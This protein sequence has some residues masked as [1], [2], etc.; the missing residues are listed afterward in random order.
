MNNTSSICTRSLL[1]PRRRFAEFSEALLSSRLCGL[2]TSLA[3]VSTRSAPRSCL[4]SIAF[5]R[6]S[7]TR[8]RA[9]LRPSSCV[10]C[11]ALAGRLLTCAAIACRL[12]HES[13]RETR[14]GRVRR[15]VR[16]LVRLASGRLLSLSPVQHLLAASAVGD[17]QG[18]GRARNVRPQARSSPAHDCRTSAPPPVAPTVEAPASPG[19]ST[20]EPAASGSTMTA[21]APAPEAPP[22]RRRY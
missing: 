19:G 21:P 20:A 5:T 7:S 1:Y 6:L 17:R 9:R 13:A 12:S 4:R 2:A 18:S 3:R 16:L 8:P 22:R 15:C 10:T 14:C 11:V